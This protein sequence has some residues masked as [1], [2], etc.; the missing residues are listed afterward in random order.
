MLSKWEKEQQGVARRF[1]I[2]AD[3]MGVE[4]V[5][6]GLTNLTSFLAQQAEREANITARSALS[7]FT[8]SLEEE[9]SKAVVSR[10]P[11]KVFSELAEQ[12]K[13]SY[14]KNN[15]DTE[16]LNLEMDFLI[17]R[18]KAG[19]IHRAMSQNFSSMVA[20][21]FNAHS[22]ISRNGIG[23][24]LDLLDANIS[25]VTASGK[26]GLDN[27]LTPEQKS[28]LEL[29]MDVSDTI[30][31]GVAELSNASRLGTTSSLD[32]KFPVLPYTPPYLADKQ[33]TGSNDI[34]VLQDKNPLLALAFLRIHNLHDWD[35]ERLLNDIREHIPNSPEIATIQ[36]ARSKREKALHD[37]PMQYAED[38]GYIQKEGVLFS[39]LG[40]QTPGLTIQFDNAV[41][42][43][44]IFGTT[45]VLK[46]KEIEDLKNL[47]PS[48]QMFIFGDLK[49]QLKNYN[50]SH[51]DHQLNPLFLEADLNEVNP[52][53]SS[54]M[55]LAENFEDV[56]LDS[57]PIIDRAIKDGMLKRLR[58]KGVTNDEAIEEG[59]SSSDPFGGINNPL[60]NM[61][62]GFDRKMRLLVLNKVLINPPLEVAGDQTFFGSDT[63]TFKKGEFKK[64]IGIDDF[65]EKH[66]TYVTAKGNPNGQY[67]H[68]AA[69]RM[70]GATAQGIY[71]KNIDIDEYQAFH[72][73]GDPV[74]VTGGRYAIFTRKMLDAEVE[75]SRLERE[76]A[77]A[78]RRKAV[79]GVL[80]G[81]DAS[82]LLYA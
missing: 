70:L 59:R 61:I 69:K 66:G 72:V 46:K 29:S 37:D 47:E 3:H 43:N 40:D 58:I 31:K 32:L 54:Y 74:F 82:G 51:K 33:F 13:S 8:F 17:N 5:E 64:G 41:K 50:L 34:K 27:Y 77:W 75:R 24:P 44:S 62:E 71:L 53:L 6:R 7:D 18:A 65:F 45:A 67:Y 48:A 38:Q 39:P 2:S 42:V 73:N 4:S 30:A 12:L 76:K 78:E 25:S 60:Y 81:A 79:T 15:F 16:E 36:I 63:T 9:A 49:E 57:Y 11:V 1:T 52:D 68:D 20:G 80:S 23:V 56:S 10:D 26:G 22:R 14:Q 19:L 21:V 55:K 28:E 35:V